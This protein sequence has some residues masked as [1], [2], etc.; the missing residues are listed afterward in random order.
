MIRR[1]LNLRTVT[2]RTVSTLNESEVGKFGLMKNDWW[3][4]V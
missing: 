2:A 4:Q 1:L 3:D